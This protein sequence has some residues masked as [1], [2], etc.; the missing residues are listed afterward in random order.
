MGLQRESENAVMKQKVKVARFYGPWEER[1]NGK[2]VKNT[3]LSES[4]LPVRPMCAMGR[5]MG[6]ERV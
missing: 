5:S 6:M 3:N 4:E 2:K 1:L